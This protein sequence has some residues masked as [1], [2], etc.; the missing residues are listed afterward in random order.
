MPAWLAAAVIV[1]DDEGAPVEQHGLETAIGARHHTDLLAEPA[2]VQEHQGGGARH[3]EEGA[4]VLEGRAGDPVPERLDTDE[5][6]EEGVGE[7]HAERAE[8]RVLQEPPGREGPA[9]EIELRPRSAFDEPLDGTVEKLHVHGLGAGPAAPDTAVDRG[10]EEDAEEEADHEEHQQHRVGRQKGG[11][12]EN[13][14]PVHDIELD[15]GLAAYPE[16]RN[17]REEPDQRP[18]EGPPAPEES[19]LEELGANPATGTVQIEGG[20]HALPALRRR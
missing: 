17:Q 13:K 16:I 4:R 6:R 7:K 1:A 12:E 14:V 2:K 10:Q 11:T 3:D 18:R 8:D 5:V 20:K 9:V 19:P 15:D